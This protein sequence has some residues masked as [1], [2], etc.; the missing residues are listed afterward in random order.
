MTPSTANKDTNPEGRTSESSEME[1]SKL[2]G[3]LVALI[4]SVGAVVGASI[5]GNALVRSK[6]D[7]E[8]IR[9]TGSARKQISSDFVIWRLQVNQRANDMAGAYSGLKGAVDKAQKFLA[10]KGV[11]AEEVFPSSIRTQTLYAPRPADEGYDYQT[12]RTVQGYELSQAVE[13]RSSNVDQI[14]KIAR[15]ITDLLSQGVNIESS[16]PSYIYTKISEEKVQ[17][18]AEAAKDARRRAEEIASNSGAKITGVRFARMSP[19]QITPEF[20]TEVSGEGINDTTSR[21]KAITAI[22]TLGFGVR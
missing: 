1:G 17:I 2:G 16:E 20:S 22:V 14:E 18:L 6:S 13:V 12:M 4:V 21:E 10:T 15:E 8:M 5:L 3:A 19:L 7:A 11:K 9:V